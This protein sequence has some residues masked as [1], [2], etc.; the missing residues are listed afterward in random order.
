LSEVLGNYQNHWYIGHLKGAV[1]DGA[2]MAVVNLQAVR[3]LLNAES[4]VHTGGYYHTRE[5][6][7]A[8]FRVQEREA[9]ILHVVVANE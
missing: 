9:S 4:E 5:A 2:E 3:M 8:G 6:D 7:R 1:F